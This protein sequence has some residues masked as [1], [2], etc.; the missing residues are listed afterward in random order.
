MYTIFTLPKPF[1][2]P[3]I[4]L[5]QNNAI[6]SW[7][8]L[9]P[10]PEIFLMGDDHGI[11][12]AAEKFGITH[13]GGIKKNKYGTPLLNNAFQIARERSENNY[14][15]Y[16]NADIIL[17]PDFAD[18]FKNLPEKE[19]LVVGGRYD[20]DVD[21][22]IDLTTPDWSKILWTKTKKNGKLHRPEGSDYFVYS[23]NSFRDIPEFAVGRVGWDNWMIWAAKKRKYMTIDATQIATLI[24]QNHDYS[25]LISPEKNKK[26]DPEQQNNI[27]I[28]LKEGY[29]FLNETDWMLTPGGY[30]RRWFPQ[31]T[32][33][34]RYLR[35]KKTRF[36]K[37]IK[38]FF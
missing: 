11:R 3:H 10:K 18:I 8:T 4:A 24:H 17:M 29:C 16:V 6:G 14:L 26:A 15:V 21:Y 12:E 2:K 23:K 7:L 1:T 5:I 38:D 34:F 9:E 30:K 13:I 35:L 25:H 22:E 27:Q 19:F 32:K 28:A 31:K 33:I 20:L 36:I 37:R